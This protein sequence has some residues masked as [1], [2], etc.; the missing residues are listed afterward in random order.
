MSKDLKESLNHKKSLAS[1]NNKKHK[2][3]HYPPTNNGFRQSS[4]V[5]NSDK[6]S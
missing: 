6:K 4:S 5:T 2:N 3:P 1:D